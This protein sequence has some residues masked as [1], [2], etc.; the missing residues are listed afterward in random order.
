LHSITLANQITSR[1]LTTAECGKD[2]KM[3][4]YCYL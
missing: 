3:T 2:R 1:F 4:A